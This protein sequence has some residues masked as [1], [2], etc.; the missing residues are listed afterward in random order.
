[1]NVKVPVC[2]RRYTHTCTRMYAHARAHTRTCVP[3]ASIRKPE[4][5]MEYLPLLL[6]TLCFE[7]ALTNSRTDQ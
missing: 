2:V 3:M 4:T 6:P 7:T 5:S 1:M